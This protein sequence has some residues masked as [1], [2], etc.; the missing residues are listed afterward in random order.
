MSKAVLVRGA[1]AIQCTSPD[2]PVWLTVTACSH[3]CSHYHSPLVMSGTVQI[4]DLAKWRQDEVCCR[5]MIRRWKAWL[6][7]FP[8]MC[9]AGGAEQKNF[10]HPAFSSKPTV[11]VSASIMVRHPYWSPLTGEN[12]WSESTPLQSI[13]WERAARSTRR[14]PSGVYR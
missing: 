7:S 13:E 4:S 6:S 14:G 2:P 10:I 9:G 12:D 11:Q 3:A 5:R 8:S 1:F